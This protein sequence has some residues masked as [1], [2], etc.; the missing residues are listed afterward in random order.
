MGDKAW[1]Q[2]EREA[3][4]LFPGGARFWA[5]AGETADFEADG[6]IG[7]VKHRK[8]LSLE[9][10]TQLAE[11]A[12]RDG[13]RRQKVGVVVLKVRRGAGRKSPLLVVLTE[14]SWRLLNGP[15][16]TAPDAV[17]V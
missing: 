6:Y 2:C 17:T 11:Q 16:A 13:V 8:A 9:A 4:K 12:D 1:K 10:I 14:Q 7:Q 5:N 15:A 3:A